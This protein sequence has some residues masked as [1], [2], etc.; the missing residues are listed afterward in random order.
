VVQWVTAQDNTT[1]QK[2]YDEVADRTS[3]VTYEIDLAG[4]S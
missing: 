4:R 2:L 1:A 3:W